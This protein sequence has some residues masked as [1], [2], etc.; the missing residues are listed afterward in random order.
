MSQGCWFCVNG[1]QVKAELL[2]SYFPSIFSINENALQM[3]TD[4]ITDFEV[5][6]AS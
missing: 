3:E 4:N 1:W 6:W 2:H 5:I